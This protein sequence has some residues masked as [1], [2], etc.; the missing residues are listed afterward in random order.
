MTTVTVLG[1]G[2]MGTAMAFPLAENGHEVRLVGTH[3]DR[4]IIDSVKKSGLHPNL[5]LGVPEGVRAYQLEEAEAAFEG[6]EIALVGVNSFGVRWAGER[7]A[8]LLRPGMDVLAVTK[9][10]EATE[11]GDLRILPDVM[12]ERVPEEL[13][14]SVSWSAIVGPAIAGE[15]AVGHETCVVFTGEEAEVLDRLAGIFRTESYHVWTSTDFVGCEVCAAVK[16]CYAFG[17]GFMDGLLDREGKTENR[18]RRFNYGSAL[19]AQAT[20]ELAGWM[21]LLGGRSDTP[22]GLPGVG[23]MLVTSLG[24]RNVRAGRFVGSGVPFSEVREKKMK[25]V[26]LEGVAAI[27]VIGGALPK[28]TERGEVGAGDFPLM[29]HL[30]EVVAEDAPVAMPWGTF[31]GGESSR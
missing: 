9:G 10:L 15:V 28:L 25:G 14:E 22:Y 18:Y 21:E 27:E 17:A 11:G 31:F 19:F 4:E 12:R 2:V 26:T 8:E 23:D 29:R 30:H 13:R 1:S 3:L 5:D 7:L 20:R 16:N 6:A 24:G